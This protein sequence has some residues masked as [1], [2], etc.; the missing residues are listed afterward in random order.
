MLEAFFKLFLV[1]CRYLLCSYDGKTI[2]F[3]LLSSRGDVV[4]RREGE[5][6]SL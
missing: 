1:G 5:D 2:D 4:Q 3:H 6:L